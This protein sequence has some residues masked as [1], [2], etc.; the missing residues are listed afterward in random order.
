VTT[1]TVVYIHGIGDKPAAEDVKQEWDLALFGNPMGTQTR[2]AYWAHLRVP[3]AGEFEALPAAA[4]SP[5]QFIEAT[6]SEIA[7]Q[8]GV[9][10]S[11]QTSPLAPWLRDMTY[12]ADAVADGESLAESQFE[13]LPLPAPLR[14]AAFRALVKVALKD[15]HAY[16]FG[17]RG[18]AIRAALQQ[19]LDDISGP[20][21][22][23]GHS[24]GSVVAYD[25]LSNPV[26]QDRTVPLFITLGSPLAVTEIQDL[27]VTPLKVPDPVAA[28]RNCCDARDVV[29][30]DKTIRGEYDPA[31]MCT[32]VLVVNDTDNHHGIG[33]YLR[34]AAVRDAV[35]AALG[36][37][38]TAQRR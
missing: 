12:A 9:L 24:L 29:A 4:E 34:A 20:V 7:L 1:P 6:L 10:E 38:A 17:G 26:N 25:V 22:V 35:T 11:L 15:V 27:V 18:P 33:P 14:K 16:F 36:A 32:D 8:T 5:E 13:V 19:V 30:L 3:D 2:M 37:I 28:W 23:I 31:A 21:I